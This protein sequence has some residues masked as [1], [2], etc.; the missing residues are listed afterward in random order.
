MTRVIGIISGKGGVGKTTF[1]ANLAIALSK[2][3]KKVLLIDC[4][5]TTPHLSY[6][7]GSKF[8]TATLN[9]VLKGNIDIK[10][11]PTAL[12]NILFLPAS[13]EIKDL[14]DVDIS[15]L[16]KHV[17][18]LAKEEDYDFVILDSAPGLGREAVSALRACQEIIFV[19]TPTIPNLSDV[20]K[21]AEVANRVGIKRFKIVLNMVRGSE[22]E[23]TPEQTN[24]MFDL[25]LLGVIPFHDSIMDSAAKGVP[26][27]WENSPSFVENIYMDIAAT[28]AGVELY[29]EPSRPSL[30]EVFRKRLKGL[31]S[32]IKF[33]R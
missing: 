27:L 30:V 13:N 6:Y 16:E 18:R 32:R 23:L 24:E 33:F 9:D 22:F 3:D 21:C 14:A 2:F 5:I 1:S 7:L 28:L 12:N 19:T 26:I 17:E 10:Y 29:R 25:P 31:R 20:T 11:A 15:K 8:H 4:N